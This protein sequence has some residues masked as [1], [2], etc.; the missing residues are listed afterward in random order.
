M[1]LFECIR[2]K[3][4]RTC[5]KPTVLPSVPLSLQAQLPFSPLSTHWPPLSTTALTYQTFT[6]FDIQTPKRG[7]SGPLQKQRASA[8]PGP[9]AS[10]L[11]S[12]NETCRSL[13]RPTP[14]GECAGLSIDWSLNQLT[15]SRSP[16]RP[17]TA[18]RSPSPCRSA[19]TAPS[20]T[21]NTGDARTPIVSTGPSY[22]ANSQF[23]SSVSHNTQTHSLSFV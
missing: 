6:C 14:T 9:G 22:P 23:Y 13:R 3:T 5:S 19:S 2:T 18:Q 7:P 16:K 11:A 4:I 8:T 15:R 10:P 21:T 1:C 17:S 12:L 20:P